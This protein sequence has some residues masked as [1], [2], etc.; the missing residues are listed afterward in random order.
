MFKIKIFPAIKEE[1]LPYFLDEMRK[2]K[3]IGCPD[4]FNSF[5]FPIKLRD[6]SHK[7]IDILIVGEEMTAIVEF[8]DTKMGNHMRVIANGLGEDKLILKESFL[9]SDNLVLNILPKV[10]LI[11]GVVL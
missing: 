11:R 7:I 10:N 9:D 3:L 8:L 2:D 4:E 1:N 6:V 5:N